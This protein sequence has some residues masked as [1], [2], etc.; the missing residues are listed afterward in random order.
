MTFEICT[1]TFNYLTT[2]EHVLMDLGV[3]ILKSNA[4]LYIN[5]SETL[6]Y[7]EIKLV[8]SSILHYRYY[9]V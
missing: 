8:P 4:T 2:V 5:V 1:M 6:F 9:K 7:T 3:D